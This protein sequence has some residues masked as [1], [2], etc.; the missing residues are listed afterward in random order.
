MRSGRPHFL[1]GNSTVLGLGIAFEPQA[2]TAI[3]QLPPS[4]NRA[5]ALLI[6]AILA[7]HIIWVWRAPPSVQYSWRKQITVRPINLSAMHWGIAVGFAAA[8]TTSSACETHRVWIKTQV[9]L[10]ELDV[11]RRYE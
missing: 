11:M 4:V 6:L 3:D 7:S 5:L 8:Q 10:A 9:G 1:A 2:A